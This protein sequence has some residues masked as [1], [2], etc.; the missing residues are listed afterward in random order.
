MKK[1]VPEFLVP[2]GTIYW[3]ELC[4]AALQD[5]ATWLDKL[6]VQFQTGCGGFNERLGIPRVSALGNHLIVKRRGT[7]P[8]EFDSVHGSI[9]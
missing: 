2:D 7:L 3:I 4:P 1:V 9:L 5:R 8:R 6:D